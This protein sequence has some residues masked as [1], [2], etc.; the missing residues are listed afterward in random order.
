M[1]W[2]LA[3]VG[4]GPAGAATAMGAQGAAPSM[5]VVGLGPADIPWEQ[6]AFDS[7]REALREWTGRHGQMP[8]G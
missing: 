5:Y 4:A 2:D 7:T 6:L 3:V 1:I 8:G